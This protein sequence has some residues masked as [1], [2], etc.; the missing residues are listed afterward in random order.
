M[1]IKITGLEP[2]IKLATD[3]QYPNL[4][5]HASLKLID[6]HERYFTIS[7]FTIRKSKYDG[8]PY[9]MPPSKRMGNGFFKFT[10]I[11]KSLW[12]EI[13]KE[14]LAEYEKETIPVVE[15]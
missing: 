11:E 2:K 8:K 12:K 7:G 9:L 4:L 10:L 13:E 5:A 1:K 15:E 14:T 3:K 6:E